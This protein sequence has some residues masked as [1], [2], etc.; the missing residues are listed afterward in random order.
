VGTTTRLLLP[1]DV[2]DR[3]E[4]GRLMCRHLA[5]VSSAVIEQWSVLASSA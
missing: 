2:D 4:R 5:P 3:D 1:G